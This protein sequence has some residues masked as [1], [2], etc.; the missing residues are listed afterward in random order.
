M[1]ELFGLLIGTVRVALRG[2]REL[3]LENLLLRQQ[4]AV[5]LR[6][7]RPRLQRRDK[8]FWVLVHRLVSGRR[9][10]WSTET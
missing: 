5:A 7:R 2:R 9:S 6:P 1:L 10:L 4:L 8:L 3:L